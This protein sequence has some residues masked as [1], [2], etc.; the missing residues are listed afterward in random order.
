MDEA[1][2][3]SQRRDYTKCAYCG[4]VATSRDHV[5]PKALFVSGRA[6]LIRVPSCETHNSGRS[7]LDF[8]LLEFVG[9]FSA[10]DYKATGNLWA[11]AKSSIYRHKRDRV[12]K[13]QTKFLPNGGALIGFEAAPFQA[14]LEA[15]VRG[16]Y[17]HHTGKCLPLD[18]RIT[19]GLWK[20]DAVMPPLNQF[21][22]HS[23]AG[24]QFVYA[25]LVDEQDPSSSA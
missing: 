14:S 24:G 1:K 16:L 3:R 18:A 6:N 12:L 25:F 21:H 23:V 13:Q 4:A 22:T 9:V 19:A 17:W 2:R 7:T 5:P 11:A 8:R 10:D 20:Q 15:I